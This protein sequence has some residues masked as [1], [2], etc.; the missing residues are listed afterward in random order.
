M[1]LLPIVKSSAGLDVHLKMIVVTLLQE[2]DNGELKETVQELSTY[3]DKL[4]EL[5]DWLHQK[6]LS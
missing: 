6:K 3:P 1:E 5:V 4:N 2:L